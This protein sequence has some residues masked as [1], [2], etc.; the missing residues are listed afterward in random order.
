MAVHPY[1]LHQ[2][3]VRRKISAT[4][5]GARHFAEPR[6]RTLR[7][8]SRRGPEFEWCTRKSKAH[9][10]PLDNLSDPTPWSIIRLRY[11]LWQARLAARRLQ[12]TSELNRIQF[13]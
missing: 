4:P 9:S 2:V 12:K 11:L 1:S 8:I 3:I 6:C 7:G 10:R 13:G 5:T